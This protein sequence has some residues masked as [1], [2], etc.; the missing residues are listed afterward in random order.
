MLRSSCLAVRVRRV[1]VQQCRPFAVLNQ[2]RD[3]AKTPE[4]KENK[5]RLAGLVEEMKAKLDVVKQGKPDCF[6]LAPSALCLVRPPHRALARPPRDHPQAA[7][8]APRRCTSPAT[9]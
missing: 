4:F 1:A 8:P 6:V 9:S 2:F 7:E 5:E 3:S